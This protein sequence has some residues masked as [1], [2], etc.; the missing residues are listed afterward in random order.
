MGVQET[1]KLQ[2]TM[3]HYENVVIGEKF[4]SQ[5]S[6]AVQQGQKLRNTLSKW[7]LKK[8]SL[9]NI[10]KESAKV[11]PHTKSPSLSRIEMT[12]KYKDKSK[13]KLLKEELGDDSESDNALSK[14]IRDFQDDDIAA[15]ESP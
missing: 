7:M 4:E 11:S 3:K 13:G 8:K 9:R 1:A 14:M 12:G 5:A 15:M 2:A 6:L 10:P